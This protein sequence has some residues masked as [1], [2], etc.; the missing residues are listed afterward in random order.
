MDT[1]TLEAF[2]ARN[3]RWPCNHEV[4][5]E[6]G[7][8][9][10]SAV[11]RRAG[12]DDGQRARPLPAVGRTAS[13]K[14]RTKYPNATR[15]APKL[16][17]TQAV[18]CRHHQQGRRGLQQGR[19][20]QGQAAA[21]AVRRRQGHRF[22]VRPGRGAADSRQHRVQGMAISTRRSQNL[23]KALSLKVMPNDT[24][25][26]M[27]YELAQFYQAKGK[28]QKSLDTVE[29]WRRGRQARNG[30]FLRPGRRGLLPA[31]AVRQGH[32]RDQEGA[33]R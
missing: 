16:D 2:T 13:K 18:R 8:V 15:K 32:R 9:F 24:Y 1:G 30:R 22:Q 33:C 11:G 31:R 21:A 10:E 27:E 29:K 26:D 19:L 12:A 3:L 14:Q 25:F 4:N 7:I 5:D 6:V 23:E 28:Y 20:R 17:L